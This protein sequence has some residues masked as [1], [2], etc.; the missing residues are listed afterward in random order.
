MSHA[1]SEYVFGGGLD[2]TTAINQYSQ[3]TIIT[4]NCNILEITTFIARTPKLMVIDL[5]TKIM[6]C[7]K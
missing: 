5:K 2:A 7:A 1:S 3:T 4:E 6:C